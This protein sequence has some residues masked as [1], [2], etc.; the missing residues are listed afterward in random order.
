MAAPVLLLVAIAAV[1]HAAWNALLK[2]AADP[3]EV[4]GRALLGGT[5]LATVPAVAVWFYS[6]RPGLPLAAVMLAL[7]SAGLETVYFIFLS[8]AYRRGELSEVY[9]TARG[10]APLL[11]VLIGLSVLGE[12]PRPL[13]LVGLACLLA[14]LWLTRPP[15]RAGSALVPALL[16]G[17]MIAAYTAVDRVGVRLGPPWLY[18]YLLWVFAALFLTIVTRLRKPDAGRLPEWPRALQVGALMT[19]AYFLILYALSQAPLSLVSPL[20]ESAIVLV[21]AWGV[22]RLRETKGATLR[23]LGALVIMAGVVLVTVS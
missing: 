9:P 16:T 23:L 10:T 8:E 11:A 2:G 17:V 15:F 1:F 6:G 19:A 13:A 7:I 4:S 22:F 20:R 21:T 5:G 18:G 14:G 12:R 3:L